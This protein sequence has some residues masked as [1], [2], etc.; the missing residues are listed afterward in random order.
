MPTLLTAAIAFSLSQVALSLLLLARQPRW[1]LREQLFGLLML[2]VVGYLLTPVLAGSNFHIVASTLQTA[3]PGMFWLFSAS[4]FDDH[5]KLRYWQ[6]G[7]VKFTVLMPLAGA[8]LGLAGLELNWLFYTLPQ[9]LEFCLL[10]LTLWVVSQHWRTDLVESRRRLRIWFVGCNGSYLFI[11]IFSREILF[12]GESW[13]ATWEYIPPALLLLAIN[14]TLL[15]YREGLLFLRRSP[16]GSAATRRVESAG[17]DDS[18]VKGLQAHMEAASP[19]RE[20]GLTIGQLAQQLDVPQYRLRL[21]IN[22]GLGFRN[23]SDFLNSYRIA[24]AAARLRNPAETQLPVLT[25]AMDAGFRSLSSFNKAFK[26]AQGQT[27]T[28]WRKART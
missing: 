3:V 17:V 2:A 22:S 9:G 18:L 7:L 14:A 8:L 6:I 23:F 11:L 16:S 12:P 21:A 27:P 24:E 28:A 15:Q 1:G 26:Q 10:A 19:W 20:M 25:I 5:F 4:V 13:L